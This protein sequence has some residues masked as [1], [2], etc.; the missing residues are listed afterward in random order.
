M[1]YIYSDASF[2]KKSN[3]AVLGYVIVES[4]ES[5]LKIPIKPSDIVLIKEQEDNNIRA[6]FKAAILGLDIVYKELKKTNQLNEL[7]TLYTDCQTISSLSDRRIKLEKNNFIAS[8]S[9]KIL[10]NADLYKE[11]YNIYDQL[12]LEIIWLKGHDKK[13]NMNFIKSNFA[14]LDKSVRSKLRGHLKSI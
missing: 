11:F 9:G 10:N 2:D 8:S 12:N 1:I 14:V 7:V 13:S 5:H 3:T 4:E 6:E